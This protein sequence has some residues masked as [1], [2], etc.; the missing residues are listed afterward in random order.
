MAPVCAG[1]WEPREGQGQSQ[2]G[3][4]EGSG[5]LMSKPGPEK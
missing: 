1:P 3:E 4:A 5:K 2:S